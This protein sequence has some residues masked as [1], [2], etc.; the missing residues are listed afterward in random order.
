MILD[1]VPKVLRAVFKDEVQRRYGHI[2]DDT[3]TSGKWLLTK[4]RIPRLTKELRSDQEKLLKSGKTADWDI[5]LLSHVLRSQALGLLVDE[6]PGAS[7]NVMP[8]QNFISTISVPAVSNLPRNVV[9][10]CKVLID[11]GTKAFPGHISSISRASNQLVLHSQVN[12]PKPTG[13]KVYVCT[14]AY[15][16]VDRL[17]NTRNVCFGHMSSATTPT[18]DLQNLFTNVEQAYDDLLSCPTTEIET[19]GQIKTGRLSWPCHD[20]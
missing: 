13:A 19:L 18:Q 9:V 1:H 10:G 3:P 20:L 15:E 16:A 4:P 8:Q 5:T 6:I 7:P 14:L 12:I 11:N 17:R 2:W